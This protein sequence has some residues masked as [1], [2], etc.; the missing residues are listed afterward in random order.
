[1]A[2]PQVPLCRILGID[3]LKVD[4]R[5]GRVRCAPRTCGPGGQAALR[6][7]PRACVRGESD[8]SVAFHGSS[9]THQHRGGDAGQPQGREDDR[10]TSEAW[11]VRSGRARRCRS[12]QCCGG[13]RARPSAGQRDSGQSQARRTPA[14][15]HGGRCPEHRARHGSWRS[16]HVRAPC[17]RSKRACLKET[18]SSFG[19]STDCRMAP[20]SRSSRH[21][22]NSGRGT[23]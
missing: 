23:P 11:H 21:H 5:F 1:M 12:R 20:Q 2:V 6:R 17:S 16:V 7:L 15:G 4:I 14:Q 3:Q 8:L 13:S 18:E 22:R 19:A 9:H 10:T